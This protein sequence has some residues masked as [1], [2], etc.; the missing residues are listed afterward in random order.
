MT[1]KLMSFTIGGIWGFATRGICPRGGDSSPFMVSS[2]GARITTP[3]SQIGC[4]TFLPTKNWT[5][6]P[7]EHIPQWVPFLLQQLSLTRAKPKFPSFAGIIFK[8]CWTANPAACETESTESPLS[9]RCLPEHPHSKRGSQ[10]IHKCQQTQKRTESSGRCAKK[11]DKTQTHPL[12]TL[13]LT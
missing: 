9:L 11:R 5:T 1:N 7:M 13:D 10:Q 8:A 12:S 6:A 3:T 2:W 4:M